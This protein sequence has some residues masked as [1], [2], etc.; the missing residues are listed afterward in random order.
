M[1]DFKTVNVIKSV[2]AL[3]VNLAATIMAKALYSLNHCRE[4]GKG[5]RM[6]CL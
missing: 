2:V 4:A 3:R 1:I 6:C 5:H